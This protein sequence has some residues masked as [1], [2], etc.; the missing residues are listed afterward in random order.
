[1]TIAS[2]N[3]FNGP[4]TLSLTGQ[5]SGS[6]ATFSPNPATGTATLTVQTRGNTAQKAYALTIK[7]VS[8]S[9]SHTA[10]ASLTVTR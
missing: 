8:G 6:T 7:G 3:G 2:L 1:M 4:V 9:L 10:S 5:P